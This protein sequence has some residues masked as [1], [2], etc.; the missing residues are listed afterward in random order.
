MHYGQKVVIKLINFFSFFN[1]GA[2]SGNQRI[3]LM[4]FNH[5]KSQNI[6]V[7]VKIKS[8]MRAKKLTTQ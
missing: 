3:F 1:S 4:N 7:S 2:V 6:R 5:L 8:V